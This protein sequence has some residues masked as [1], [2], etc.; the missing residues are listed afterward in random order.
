[1]QWFSFNP[2][3]YILTENTRLSI[4]KFFKQKKCWEALLNLVSDYIN[5]YEYNL[6][7]TQAGSKLDL[8]WAGH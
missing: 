4:D 1:M 7:M 2:Y 8:A 5:A 6:I 3:I